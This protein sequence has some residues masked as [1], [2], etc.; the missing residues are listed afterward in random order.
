MPIPEVV[1]YLPVLFTRIRLSNTMAFFN[2]DKYNNIICVC[3]YIARARLAKYANQRP[4]TDGGGD[5]DGR[6]VATGGAAFEAPGNRNPYSYPLV[7]IG[8]TSV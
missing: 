8:C 1:K 3:L 2:Y 6:V 5:S 4:V 7:P